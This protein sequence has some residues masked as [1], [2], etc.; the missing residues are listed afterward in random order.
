[1]T[2]IELFT[3][4]SSRGLSVQRAVDGLECLGDQSTITDEM[5]LALKEHRDVFLKTLPKPM[6]AA[7]VDAALIDLGEWLNREMPDDYKL[8]CNE[9]FW[10]D[11][12]RATEKA[13]AAKSA[14]AFDQLKA[15]AKAEFDTFTRMLQQPC[16]ICGT[17][18]WYSCSC[19]WSMQIFS[20]NA[21]QNVVEPVSVVAPRPAVITQDTIWCDGDVRVRV[22]AG[23]PVSI[24]SDG[25][26]Q[27]EHDVS[28]RRGITDNLSAH[29][30]LV[31]VLLRNKVRVMPRCDLK[32]P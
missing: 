5:Q 24:L 15:R 21:V 16:T 3:A 6:T 17:V 1:M 31:P 26:E 4:L 28:A 22:P 32:T 8:S 11:F 13:V 2:L 29:P 19:D 20:E 23:E 12:D 27:H 14:A 25:W 10:Q 7:E 9:S 18:P 30:K